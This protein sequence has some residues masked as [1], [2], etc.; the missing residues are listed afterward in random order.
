MTFTKESCIVISTKFNNLNNKTKIRKEVITISQSNTIEVHRVE[1]RYLPKTTSV[2]TACKY[3]NNVYNQLLYIN[4][5]RYFNKEEL[6]FGGNLERQ[7]KENNKCD[8]DHNNCKYLP[9]QT[10]QQIIRV[11]DKEWNSYLQA[12]KSY[13]KDKSK[14]NGKPKPPKYKDKENEFRIIL[15]NQNVIVKDGILICRTKNKIDKD[16]FFKPIK[17][18]KQWKSRKLMEVRIVP[19]RG[20]NK[21]YKLE[22]IYKKPIDIKPRKPTDDICRVLSIDLGLNNSCTITS[23]IAGFKPVLINGKGLK[24]KNLNFNYHISR[25]QSIAIRSNNRRST[26]QILSLFDK[27]NNV[28]TNAMHQTSAYVKHLCVKHNIDVVI[29]GHNKR[30]KQKNKLKHFVQIPIFSLI[31]YLK[32]KLKEVGVDVIEVNERYTSGTSFLDGELPN[33]KHYNKRRRVNRGLF[34]TNSGFKINAD[35]NG[36]LQIMKGGFTE[37]FGETIISS[38]TDILCRSVSKGLLA[39]PVKINLF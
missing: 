19:I 28:M 3:A 13:L 31:G 35:V 14:F 5:Q 23:N 37:I 33:K 10:T 30:Q 9:A 8:P 29:I 18:S 6:L 16:K 4:R 38:D 12:T 24:S 21:F 26:K 27:R 39:N 11:L 36:S 22:L 17:L 1:K 34:V 32:Y 15:T 7:L 20:N 25:L 2:I